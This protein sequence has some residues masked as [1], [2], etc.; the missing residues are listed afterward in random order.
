MTYIH[1]RSVVE[2]CRFIFEK[3][4]SLDALPEGARI[5][6]PN[7]PV[8]LG[9]ALVLLHRA[10]L[11]EIAETDQEK[12]STVGDILKNPKNSNLLKWKECT[13]S[14]CIK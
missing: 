8:N 5:V 12:L 13:N 3:Y 4:S 7:D 10:G 1:S 6:I 14:A 9:R 11:I 2:S